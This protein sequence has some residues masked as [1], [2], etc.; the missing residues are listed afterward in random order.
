MNGSTFFNCS[1]ASLISKYRGESEKIVRCLFNMARHYAPSIIFFDEADALVS[2]RG[3]AGEHE[4]SRRLKTEILVAMDGIGSVS[5]E[6][7]P[8]MV[9]AATNCPWDLDDAIIRRLE[10]RIHIPLPDLPARHE[11][12]ALNLRDISVQGDVVV[13]QLASATHG[14]SG[15][16]IHLVCREASMMPMRRLIEGKSPIEIQAMRDGGQLA[17]PTVTMRDFELVRN[18]DCCCSRRSIR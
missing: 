3:M 13:S 12:F 7:A 18:G 11:Q 5:S 4:A 8:V 1:T 6:R 14:Y 9:L 17:S 16:D 10:K 15:A 2:S